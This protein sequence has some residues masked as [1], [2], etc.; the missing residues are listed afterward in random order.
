MNLKDIISHKIGIYNNKT[1]F[2]VGRDGVEGI[3]T[4]CGLDGPG[5]ESRWR[6][7]F[8]T[9]VQIGPGAHPAPY[10]MGN[11]L[12]PQGEKRPVLGVNHPTPSSAE[13][14]ERVQLYF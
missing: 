6:I 2:I 14:K 10:R 1:N 7:D 4:R 11:G 5:M 9:L 8:S 3:T 12:L 13:A